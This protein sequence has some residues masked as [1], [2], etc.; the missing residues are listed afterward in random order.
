M[1]SVISNFKNSGNSLHGGATATLV[2]LVGSAAIHTIGANQVGVSVEISVSYLD[3][4]YADVS[5]SPIIL[6]FFLGSCHYCF[7]ESVCLFIS[8]IRVI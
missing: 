2:D 6:Q 1:Y 7:P 4:A 8:K 5:V 3:A